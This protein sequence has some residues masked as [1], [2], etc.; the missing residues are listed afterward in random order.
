MR[1]RAAPQ[2]LPL[3]YHF[4]LLAVLPPVESN[5]YMSGGVFELVAVAAATIAPTQLKC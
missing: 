4:P 3:G 2:R 1:D 5:Q